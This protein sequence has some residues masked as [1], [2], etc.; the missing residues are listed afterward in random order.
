[1]ASLHHTLAAL[2]TSAVP[3]LVV[4][5]VRARTDSD[6]FAGADIETDQGEATV[7]VP[8]NAGAEVRQSAELLSLAALSEG[9]RSVLAFEI[10]QTLGITRARDTRAVVTT[11]LAGDPL[12]Y[13][14]LIGSQQL[15]WEVSGMLASIHG[16]PASIAHQGGLPV[17]DA[18][19]SEETAAR[20]LERAAQTRLL[21]QTVLQRWVRTAKTD[22]LWDFAPTVVHG[23]LDIDKLLVEGDRLLGVTGWGELAVGDPAADF[24]WLIGVD[25]TVFEA[26]VARYATLRN[27]G[28][29]PALRT[30]AQL[31]YELEFAKDLLHGV[32]L[33]DQAAI[34]QAVDRLDRLVDTLAGIAETSNAS[35]AL[36]E[37]QVEQM[38]DETPEVVDHLSETAAYE[39][40]D[41]DRQFG[42]DTDFVEPL[43]DPSVDPES[44][45]GEASGT[46]SEEQVTE[47]I[48]DEDLPR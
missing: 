21:P 31:Y 22:G 28:S 19:A 13:D 1:M 44:P 6:D 16:L 43:V 23:D 37:A 32:E 20:L 3:G 18:R 40:L 48:A 26:V 46:A 34:D 12:D 35:V 5:G 9:S 33:H 11:R 7:R 4:T 25:S 30:R 24:A 2:A 14:A 47:P 15:V 42:V 8:R 41:E 38:L 17:R 10:P 45:L 39:A 27:A 36:S 29:L